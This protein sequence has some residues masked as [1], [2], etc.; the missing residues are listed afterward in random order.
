MRKVVLG[1]LLSLTLFGLG[2]AIYLAHEH[3]AGTL[4]PCTT[5]SFLFVDCGR[6]LRSQYSVMFGV[7]LPVWG[8]IQY[9]ILTVLLL[10]TLTKNRIIAGKLAVIQ[11]LVG[12]LF[13]MYFVYLQFAVIKGICIYCMVSAFVSTFI[14][15]LMQSYFER[16]RKLLIVDIFRLTYRYIIKR[17]FFIFDP[18]R[19]HTT[20]T[21]LGAN[22]GS[23][24]I[25][26]WL[27]ASL[28]KSDLPELK[29]QIA[30]LSFGYP[31]GLAAGFD[32]EAKLGKSL[33]PWGFG[34]QSMGTLTNG[35]YEGNPRPML[36]RLIKSRSLLVNKGFKNQ[37]VSEVTKKL[38]GEIFDI[39]VGISIGRTNT[40]KLTQ[41]QS[42]DDIV[43]AFKIVEKSKTKH[44]YY[45]LNISCPNL[46][47]NVEFYS[48]K[49]L[50]K[51]L[52]AV[53]SLGLSKPLFVKMP[54]EKS[55]KETIGMLEIIAKHSPAGV[56]FGNLQK[57]RKHPQL[58]QT[59]VAKF[60]RGY[61]SGRPTFDDSNRLIKLAYKHF[62]NRFII[63]G[64]GGVFSAEDA[65]IKIKNGASLVQLITGLVFV[66]PQLIMDI[67]YRLSELIKNDG[68][69]NISQAIGVDTIA[70][71][72]SRRR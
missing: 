70:T 31:I 22:V 67:N 30:G 16:E 23:K 57:N 5:S 13:S 3:F 42:V 45:E 36:G 38:K 55:D 1:V 40:D 14:F 39:P 18:E 19:V 25:S 60:K 12:F 47:G 9:S 7:P 28:I 10:L 35:A 63:I 33:A 43:S 50:S 4:P 53:D 56:I 61:F 59:E 54:I 21:A 8:I 71:K 20:I 34:F 49:N 46:N 15:A 37:G 44:A 6:V 65:Y 72:K 51:L 48:S 41:K 26:R 11:S 29:Q 62:G 27:I 2:D 69:Q 17:V 66:G 68:Y 52:R 32:Y 58:D 64:C 24:G